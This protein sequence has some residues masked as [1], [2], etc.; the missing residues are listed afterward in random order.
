MWVRARSIDVITTVGLVLAGLTVICAPFASDLQ[1]RIITQ[2]LL[3]AYLAQC[4]NLAGGY[5]GQ[6]SLGHSAFFGVGGYTSSLLLVRL[7]VSP[8]LGMWL[9]AALAG[10]L[11]IG[12]SLV[13]FRYKVKGTYFALFTLA[14]TTVVQSVVYALDVLGGP[15]GILLPLRDS[16]TDLLL[17]GP[18]PYFYLILSM[19]VGLALLTRRLERHRVGRY[20][21]AVREDE[22]AAEASGVDA[23]RWKC[24]AMGL[25]GFLVALGG[26][27]Y[28][29][30]FRYVSP[31]TLLSFDPT[32]QMLLGTMVG[33][34]GTVSGPIIGGLLFNLLGEALRSLPFLS[35]G[36]K[37]NVLTTIIYAAVLILT[38]LYLPGGLARLL[39]RRLTRRA[40]GGAVT[41]ELSEAMGAG[42]ESARAA[43]GGGVS[44]AQS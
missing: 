6:F 30:Y 21:V 3:F 36:T 22:L 35:M 29:Q 15:Q 40:P 38:V 33:G 27:F 12:L 26:T 4:W 43:E 39:R 41:T 19:V 23:A 16:W 34:A 8:W 28:A 18:V 37:G 17:P 2:A 25:S 9:G 24:V 11:A 32:M 1:L 20:L 14:F 13:T 5:A 31:D 10:L 7:G 42:D 44:A